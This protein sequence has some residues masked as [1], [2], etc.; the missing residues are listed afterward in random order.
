MGLKPGRNC[1]PLVSTGWKLA[2]LVFGGSFCSSQPS[3]GSNSL[4]WRLRPCTAPP[5]QCRFL[6][7]FLL[8]FF[9]LLSWKLLYCPVFIPT[10]AY[11]HTVAYLCRSPH[12][13]FAVSSSAA[14]S[15]SQLSTLSHSFLDL[16]RICVDNGGVSCTKSTTFHESWI[17][18][19]RYEQKLNHPAVM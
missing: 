10:C 9:D 8:H 11:T 14:S 5:H 6:C 1:G 12:L 18:R 19:R 4:L 15:S 16:T 3:I 7:S 2:C 17:L 13:P